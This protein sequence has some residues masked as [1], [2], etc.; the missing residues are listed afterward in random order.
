MP[1][2]L[3]DKNAYLFAF[4]DAKQWAPRIP[5]SQV[6]DQH[7]LAAP[8]NDT[9]L[10]AANIWKRGIL[11]GLEPIR[12]KY[13][14]PKIAGKH[15]PMAHQRDAA[16]FFT[17]HYRCFN[18]SDM[19]TGKTATAIWTMDYLLKT[20]Q[21]KNVLIVTTLSTMSATWEEELFNIV[22]R[23]PVILLQGSAK[24]R[25][26]PLLAPLPI[27]IINHDG[28]KIDLV[29]KHLKI[30]EFDLIV[31][32][33]GDRFSERNS[34]RYKAI[35]DIFCPTS[36]LW[37]MTGTPCPQS[38]L[39]AFAQAK[40]INPRF[41]Y[42]LFT[43]WKNDVMNRVTENRYVSA[44]GAQDKVYEALQP[45]FRV[46]KK[47]VL[48]LPPVT[49]SYRE[50]ELTAQQTYAIKKIKEENLFSLGSAKVTAVN[51]G[52]E[53]MKVRQILCGA[54]KG[55]TEEKEL[56]LAELDAQPRLNLLCEI[57]S[58]AKSKCIVFVPFTATL[59][60]V[61]EHVKNSCGLSV[62]IINGAVVGVKRN[63]ILRAFSST[64]EPEVLIANPEAAAHGLNLTAA[65]T[66]IWYAPV[67]S[68]G[69]YLQANERINRPGQKLSMR[70]VH[71]YGHSIERRLYREI[72][73]KVDAHDKLLELYR[74]FV[75]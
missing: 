67:Y 61:A 1:E 60:A 37:W 62:G 39:Q 14:F 2:I 66:I 16:A 12:F 11:E 6:I 19:A 55:I 41:P 46:A 26:A 69:T 20:N 73:N 74:E 53:L 8:F 3:K 75:G 40:L 9:T 54:V 10:L 34:Q 24:A 28:I 42:K 27:Y 52:V 32:D 64:P 47:D 4:S 44:P 72:A 23:Y 51:A 70:I 36:R 25:V 58:E 15:S 13:D 38:P 43:H 65:D 22:P 5:Q 48:D 29:R 45:A 49:Y 71:M 35:C 63:E 31:V 33:E 56:I 59:D 68:A 17:S 21:I 50:C 18:L 30:K 57:L 7:H